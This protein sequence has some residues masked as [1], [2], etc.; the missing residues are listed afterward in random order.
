[1]HDSPFVLLPEVFQKA[2]TK[3]VS[4]RVAE[5]IEGILPAPKKAM[6]PKCA[7]Y[8]GE[9]L[10]YYSKKLG[11]VLEPKEVVDV[12]SKHISIKRI[13]LG[14][15][16]TAPLL[17]AQAK[18]VDYAGLFVAKNPIEWAQSGP[19]HPL[20]YNYSG[21]VLGGN[22]SVVFWDEAG[23]NTKELRAKQLNTIQSKK[24]QEGGAP[25]IELD[26]LHLM[27]TNTKDI[28]DIKEM[29]PQDPFLD[30]LV[31][32]T[33]YWSVRPETIVKTLAYELSG[34]RMTKL[35]TTEAPRVVREEL[36]EFVPTAV[37]NQPVVTPDRRFNLGIEDGNNRIHVS[38]HALMYI[39]QIVALSRMNF[40]PKV[41]ERLK[42]RAKAKKCT[43]T[44]LLEKLIVG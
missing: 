37:P 6:C 10:K 17:P 32:T 3:F 27:A 7:Y 20:S 31:P 2:L 26:T 38:P 44:E 15:P 14:D 42:K 21:A 24:V 11:H 29:D 4:P 9:I 13:I 18:D 28:K 41:V 19:G 12:L 36:D 33:M 23:K 25:L 34:L 16:G 1:M 30:R 5:L 22:G 43:E 35:G 39:A 40:D 8:H